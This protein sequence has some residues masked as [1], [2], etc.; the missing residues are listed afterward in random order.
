MMS[1]SVVRAAAAASP[2]GTCSSGYRHLSR[3]ALG[4]AAP[5]LGRRRRVM[6]APLRPCVRRTAEALASDGTGA[7]AGASIGAEA[8]AGIDPAA[9]GAPETVSA[10]EVEVEAPSPVDN[11]QLMLQ[12]LMAENAALQVKL[13]ELA[14]RTED[15]TARPELAR[16]REPLGPGEL[17]TVVDSASIKWPTPEENPPFWTRRPAALPPAVADVC[18][19]DP[20]PMHVV[21]VTAEMAP[22]AKVGG[23]GDVVTGLARAHLCAGHN[24]EVILP[25]YSSLN[26]GDVENLKHVMNFD[27]PKGKETEWDGVRETRMEMVSTS[28]HTGVIGGCNVILLKPAAKER[29]NIFVGGK[30]YGGSYNELEAYLYFCRAALE[31]LRSSGR[32]P[33]V[34]HVHEWQCSAVA[35]LY[36]DLYFKEGMLK[37]AKV[38]LTIHN[39]DNTGECR[40]EEFIA[41]GMKGSLFNTLERAMDERTIGHNPERLCLLKGAIVYSNFVTTVSPTYAKEALNGGGGFLGKTLMKVSR[42]FGGVLN[43]VDTNLWDAAMDPVLPANFKPGSMAG[44]ALC[45]KYLQSGLGMNVDSDKPLV[46]CISR[47]VP[48]KGIDLIR[49]AITH[50]KE[51]G[52]Q[53]VLLGSGHSD[54]EFSAMA[55]AEYADD[56]DVKLLIFYS[57]PLSHLMYA[58]ADMVLVPSMFE[59]CG[60]TQMIAMCYGALPVVRKTGGLADTVFDVD[61][62]GVAE[63]LKNG[64]VFEGADYASMDRALDR[65]FEYYG[66]KKEWW[67]SMQEKVMEVDNSWERAGQEYIRIYNVMQNAV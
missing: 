2:T 26:E 23:L 33:Q 37:N 40:E 24:V 55:A 48:Q 13:V 67:A 59:P 5:T 42:K 7:E 14:P 18:E 35:M 49:H 53:F 44:K 30:I 46:V 3:A 39:M 10:T 25:F 22:I 60:L 6:G 16:V 27:V 34:L 12:A 43:G 32:D 51:Q 57:D 45:K 28:M 11:L 29:S 9:V 36:W 64:F 19:Q 65:G 61:D 4:I 47:L 66:A 8:V 63:H 58:A 50:T 20:N 15:V 56:P 54:P 1:S 52:G 41:T 31:C 62:A 21:H 17:L 38:M